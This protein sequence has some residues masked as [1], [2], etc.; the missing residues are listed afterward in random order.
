[1]LR[2]AKIGDV[3]Q[4]RKLINSHADK[5]QMLHRSLNELYEN[6]RDFH[7]AEKKGRIVACCALHIDWKDLAE[8]KCLAVAEK[9]KKK[10][11]GTSLVEACLEEAKALGGVKVF[12]LT[13]VTEFFKEFGFKRI[14]K[15]ELPHKIWNECTKCPRFPD[16]DEVPMIKKI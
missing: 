3:E 12:A 1:M 4:I 9:W 6:I 16:C 13:Y 8:I 10:G 14:R 7:V 11:L 2:K 5:G 15:E